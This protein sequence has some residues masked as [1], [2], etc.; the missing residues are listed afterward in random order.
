MIRIMRKIYSYLFAA[1]AIFTAASCQKDMAD[2]TPH[3]E[4]YSITAL[5]GTT[6]TALVDGVKTYWTPGDALTAFDATGANRKFTTAITENAASA[7]FTTPEF[8]LP[9]DLSSAMLLAVYPY[10]EGASTDFKTS[11]TGLELPAVQT[12][13]EGG[14][15]SSATIAYTLSSASQQNS[16]KFSNVYGLFKF[17]V[18]DEGVTKVTVKANGGECLAGKVALTLDGNL[19]AV[20]GTSEVTLEGAFVK[21]A[22]YYLAAIPGTYASGITVYFNDVEVKSTTSGVTLSKNVVL[23]LGELATPV[24]QSKYL[25]VKNDMGWSKVNLYGWFTSDQS[26]FNGSWPGTALA[27]K[28]LA[29][30]NEFY[31]YEIPSVC[32]DKEIGIVFNDGSKQLSDYV[33]TL[34]GDTYLRLTVTG[35]K[36]VDPA[37]ATSFGYTIYVY[38]QNGKKDLNIYYWGVDGAPEWPGNDLT[39]SASY[40]GKTFF[41]YEIPAVAY[42]G[43]TF[44][45]IINNGSTQTGDI[46]A[47]NPT[48]DHYIG[49]YNNNGGKGFWYNGTVPFTSPSEL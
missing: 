27:E 39:Q 40:D 44:N 11:V 13:C 9:S 49:Y 45:Y 42:S 24:E 6:K 26:T 19:V 34:T 48:A 41:Y 15:D 10:T 1:V 17:V 43:T 47:V 21:G 8:I 14:F 36:V 20:E 37:V 29:E 5:A 2:L 32:L 4:G 18:A 35:P 7:T 46:A 12:A 25:Y 3:A 28:V 23:G 33:T 30:G 22:T 16:L 38:D 31:R